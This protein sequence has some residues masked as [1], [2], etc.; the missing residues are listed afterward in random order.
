[1]GRGREVEVRMVIAPGTSIKRGPD[2]RP[3]HQVRDWRSRPHVHV[4]DNSE[5]KTRDGRTVRYLTTPE[6]AEENQVL[7]VAGVQQEDKNKI[8]P[9]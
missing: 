3:I 4:G 8:N 9:W 7:T 1:M 2:G 5:R 6:G